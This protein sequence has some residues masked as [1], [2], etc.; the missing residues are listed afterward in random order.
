MT[1]SVELRLDGACTVVFALE[2]R[3]A[4]SV[5][6]AIEF[7]FE[8]ID[9]SLPPVRGCSLSVA[10]IERL[11]AYADASLKGERDEGA[12]PFAAYDAFFTLEFLEDDGVRFMASYGPK[13]LFSL[14]MEGVISESALASFRD[15]WLRQIQ[16]GGANRA[17]R[18][19]DPETG[20]SR[21][22]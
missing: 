4:E 8:E 3:K 2:S 20:L 7:Q 22:G 14:G 5:H 17:P 21:G 6:F 12:G 19:V 18:A 11:A 1:R 16:N 9:A 15:G 13:H 10:D